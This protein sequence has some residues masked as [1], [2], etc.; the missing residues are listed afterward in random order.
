[1]PTLGAEAGAGRARRPHH[2]GEERGGGPPGAVS[3]TPAPRR[4]APRPEPGKR[5]QVVSRGRRAARLGVGTQPGRPEKLVHAEIEA[6]ATF[7]S[8]SSRYLGPGGQGAICREGQAVPRRQAGRQ[9][10]PPVPAGMGTGRRSPGERR[11][12]GWER[13]RG[14]PGLP[15]QG[16]CLR[17]RCPRPRPSS[18]A[19]LHP[20]PPHPRG[21]RF[22]W[23][24]GMG[25]DAPITSLRN[26]S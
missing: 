11:P 8:V 16:V 23:E 4:A 13:G 18:K 6:R 19:A 17:R 26:G 2:E 10:S 22:S 24:R 15:A 7:I 1:M 12:A 20:P 21:V 9:A 14:R 5:Q 25:W 3:A